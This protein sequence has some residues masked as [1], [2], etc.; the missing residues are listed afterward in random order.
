MDSGFLPDKVNPYAISPIQEMDTETNGKAVGVWRDTEYIVMHEDAEL[1]QRCIRTG[2]PTTLYLKIWAT[3]V[4]PPGT[5]RIAPPVLVVPLAQQW[6]IFAA[7]CNQDLK[8]LA[9]IIALTAVVIAVCIEAIWDFPRGSVESWAAIAATLTFIAAASWTCITGE[10]LVRVRSEGKYHWL[11]GADRRFLEH[12][13]QWVP[14]D[15]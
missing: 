2:E 14:F 7:S 10:M 8:G 15:N 13:P 5:F 9:F 1:P 4:V 6:R 3:W 11:R 12:L